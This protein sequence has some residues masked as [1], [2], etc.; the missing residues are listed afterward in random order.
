MFCYIFNQADEVT[1]KLKICCTQL[2]RQVKFWDDWTAAQSTPL[3]QVNCEIY[4]SH[5]TAHCSAIAPASEEHRNK[6]KKW[7]DMLNIF[8]NPSYFRNTPLTMTGKKKNKLHLF[9]T[10]MAIKIYTGYS[11]L[12]HAHLSCVSGS[13]LSTKTLLYFSHDKIKGKTTTKSEIS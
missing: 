12:L 2:I 6:T 8:I 1:F 13:R 3:Q 11:S 5:H 9:P 4:L 10:K 7:K